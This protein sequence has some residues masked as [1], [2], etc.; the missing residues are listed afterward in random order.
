MKIETK[1]YARPWTQKIVH[2][3][4]PGQMSSSSENWSQIWFRFSNW[5]V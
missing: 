5:P 4:L 3:K 1:N 2:K